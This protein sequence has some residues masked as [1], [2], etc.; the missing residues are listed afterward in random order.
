VDGWVTGSDRAALDLAGV[1]DPPAALAPTERAED[2]RLAAL[3]VAGATDVPTGE[4]LSRG[5]LDPGVEG[6]A[7]QPA[8]SNAA[9][10]EPTPIRSLMDASLPEFAG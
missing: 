10:A 6:A 9:A 7:V 5:A 8:T 1:D 3:V 2:P 4:L